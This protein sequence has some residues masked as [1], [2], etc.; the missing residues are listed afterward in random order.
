[1]FANEIGLKISEN[2]ISN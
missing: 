2:Y 1:V